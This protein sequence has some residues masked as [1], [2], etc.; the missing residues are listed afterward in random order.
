MFVR[1]EQ[2]A[3]LVARHPDVVR[4]RVEVTHD[5]QRDKMTVK[6]E[7]NVTDAAAFETIVGEVLKLNATIELVKPGQLPRDGI[8]IADLR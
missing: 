6:L 2:I 7:T 1:P 5:G 8:V 3:D 4:A